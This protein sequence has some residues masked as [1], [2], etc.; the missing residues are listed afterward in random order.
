MRLQEP[1]CLECLP[2]SQGN[3]D[4]DIRYY[5]GIENPADGIYGDGKY[6]YVVE[7]PLG[8]TSDESANLTVEV[9]EH[10]GFPRWDGPTERAFDL[11]NW[12]FEGPLEGA[13]EEL[14][15]RPA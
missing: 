10:S 4:A 11:A 8:G 2:G 6:L 7:I 1:P 9:S 12:E 3:V 5:L 14:G 15:M 13:V